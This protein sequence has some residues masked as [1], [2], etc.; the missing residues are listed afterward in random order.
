VVTEAPVAQTNVG[1]GPAWIAEDAHRR[2]GEINDLL[3]QAIINHVPVMLCTTGVSAV[4]GYSV[5]VLRNVG[6]GMDSDALGEYCD[7]KS[8][9]I[10]VIS[11]DRATKE[12]TVFIWIGRASDVPSAADTLGDAVTLPPDDSELLETEV[13]VSAENYTADAPC[14][15]AFTLTAYPEPVA[16]MTFAVI[17]DGGTPQPIEGNVFSPAASGEYRFALLDAAG[18]LQ[19]RSAAFCVTL[20]TAETPTASE[21]PAE[22]QASPE[23]SV[24][25][26][27]SESPEPT[28]TPAPEETVLTTD[29]ITQDVALADALADVEPQ[30]PEIG[31]RAY[32]YSEGTPTDVTPQFTLSGAPEQGGYYYALSINGGTLVRLLSNTY[33]VTK[34]GDFTLSFSLLDGNDAVVD[35]S[36]SYHVIVDYADAASHNQA[37]MA[38]GKTRQYGSLASLL[39]R[40][41]DGA[42]IYLLTSDVIVLADASRLSSVTLAADPD[43]FGD[44]A[45]VVVSSNNPDMDV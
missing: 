7:G 27:P 34:S 9:I 25:P 14:T 6:F 16:G 21:T 18:V 26:D 31:V 30:T 12:Q 1:S 15:P 22:G 41:K 17:V 32:D 5:D 38:Q 42:T 40:A 45:G 35:T 44:G 20:A 33:A 4:Y 28:E 2:Y 8:V 36:G 37:W 39:S 43:T 24:S 11:P 19:G 10:S 29:D 23:P 13:E 3:E